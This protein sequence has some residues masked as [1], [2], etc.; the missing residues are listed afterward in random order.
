MRSN[1]QF[2]FCIGHGRAWGFTLIE[3][4]VV[5]SIVA[6]LV[7]ILLPALGKA[8]A[9]A[10][11]A[12]CMANVKQ[13]ASGLLM[14]E[15]DNGTFPPSVDY[16]NTI[17]PPDG[18]IGA[19]DDWYWLQF[20]RM[21]LGPA[22]GDEGRSVYHCPAKKHKIDALE[23]QGFGVLYGNYAVNYGICRIKNDGSG[24]NPEYAGRPLGMRHIRRPN[25][26][27]LVL[28]HGDIKARWEH[29]TPVRWWQSAHGS[30]TPKYFYVPGTMTRD[31]EWFIPLSILYDDAVEDAVDGRHPGGTVN[32]GFCDGSVRR[33]RA[34]DLIVDPDPTYADQRPWPLWRP[35][36]TIVDTQ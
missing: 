23:Q 3:L 2:R 24:N 12:V 32:V 19:S 18:W 8:R 6:L 13:L 16:T 17:E 21:S 31:S 7:S 30:T 4:L 5:V 20:A 35:S 22:T 9:Q 34:R 26:T 29:T 11:A 27:L 33:M 1:R 36:Q 14:Y 28:D 10:K 25:S 15:M